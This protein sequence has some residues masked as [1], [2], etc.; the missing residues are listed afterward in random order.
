VPD[1]PTT[2]EPTRAWRRAVPFVLAAALVAFVV[3]RLDFTAFVRALAAV[4]APRFVAFAALFVL[5]LLTADAFATAIVYRRTAPGVTFRELW[6]LRGASYLPSLLNHHV[7]QAFVTVAVAR[8]HGVPIARVAGATLVV[9]ASWMG[10]ILGLGVAALLVR[11]DALVLPIAV[12]VVGLGYLALVAWRPARLARVTVLAP[13]FEAGVGGHLV[14]LAA[15][16]PHVAA[17]FLGTWLPFSFFGVRV[18]FL[19]ALAT[20]PVMMV[21]VTLPIT[22]QGFGTRD[23]LAAHFFEGFAAGDTRAARL[24]AVAAATASFGVAITLIELCIGVAL[25]RGALKAS[26]RALPAPEPAREVEA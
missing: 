2:Q 8:R 22:P 1:G 6:A 5:S 14:A 19:E 18:P 26:A 15:R 16:L 24:A 25:F 20:V 23:V 10:A 13:L 17:L 3:A 9:Y 12:V 21:V 7:G 11:G 4:D